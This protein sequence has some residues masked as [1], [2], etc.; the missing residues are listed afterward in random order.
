MIL[1]LQQVNKYKYLSDVEGQLN[2]IK[3]VEKFKDAHLRTNHINQV[4]LE[5]GQPVTE[6]GNAENT[7]MYDDFLR[8]LLYDQK[9]VLSDEDVPL[10]VDKVLNFFK[11]A[12]N[13][14]AGREIWKPN[15]SSNH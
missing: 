8:V 14:V 15:E 9:Y 2:L 1:Y 7:K 6:K 3:S 5:N 13:T 4:V 11:K 12:V 10:H